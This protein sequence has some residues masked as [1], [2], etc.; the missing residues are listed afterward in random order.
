MNE[1][2]VWGIKIC[3]GRLYFETAAFIAKTIM[4]KKHDPI[5]LKILKNLLFFSLISLIVW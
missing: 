1:E 4:L 5:K 2:S 3:K